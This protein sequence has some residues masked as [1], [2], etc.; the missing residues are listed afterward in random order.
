MKHLLLIFSCLFANIGFAQN[1]PTVR[2]EGDKCALID[3]QCKPIT[4][5]KYAYIDKFHENLALA[6]LH[7]PTGKR[8]QTYLNPKGQEI[9]SPTENQLF[10]FVAGRAIFKEKDKLGFLDK[11]GRAVVPATYKK[12]HNYSEGVA[13]VI[14][15][16]DKKMFIDEAGEVAFQVPEKYQF[17][18]EKCQNG[19][20]RVCEMDKE[21]P[22]NK[23][24]RDERIRKGHYV[25]FDKT[26]EI[27]LDIHQKMPMNSY[28]SAFEN[29]MALASLED[30]M[31]SRRNADT[32]YG[33]I[34][35]Q[36]NTLIPIKYDK[37]E[38]QGNLFLL[39]TLDEISSREYFGLHSASGKEVLPCIYKNIF[40]AMHGHYVVEVYK[41]NKDNVEN[42]SYDQKR[43]SVLGIVDTLGNTVI[44]PKFKDLWLVSNTEFLGYMPEK[45][46]EINIQNMPLKELQKYV[47]EMINQ[48]VE[49]KGFFAEIK[50]ESERK[51]TITLKE[52]IKSF[53]GKF[54]KKIEKIANKK[55]YQAYTFA[56]KPTGEATDLFVYNFYDEG[57]KQQRRKGL[58]PVQWGE[59]WALANSENK[60]ILTE[61][62]DNIAPFTIAQSKNEVPMLKNKKWL[63]MNQNFD[64]AHAFGNAEFTAVKKGGKWA[65]LYIS[66]KETTPYQYDSIAPNLK[67]IVLAVPHRPYEIVFEDNRMDISMTEML[68]I[69]YLPAHHFLAYQNKKWG[70]VDGFGKII[71]PFE[72]DSIVDVFYNYLVV[73]RGNKQGVINYAGKTLVDFQQ[74]N[75]EIVNDI[76]YIRDGDKINLYNLENKQI[77]KQ[78]YDNITPRND[79]T[80]IVKKDKKIGWIDFD[81]NELFPPIYDEIRENAMH[82]SRMKRKKNEQDNPTFYLLKKDQKQGLANLEY[83]IIIPCVYDETDAYSLQ[84]DKLIIVKQNN[85]K[86]IVNFKNEQILPFE[87]DQ[88]EGV[89]WH[90][91]YFKGKVLIQKDGKFGLIDPQGKQIL[92][93]HYD[94]IHALPRDKKI[95]A[96]FGKK[97]EVF[98]ENMKIVFSETWEDRHQWNDIR[99]KDVVGVKKN[100]KWGFVKLTGE[101]VIPFEYN[102]IMPFQNFING[103]S[104]AK[105]RKGKKWG[106]I[107][108]GGKVIIPCQYDAIENLKHFQITTITV[109]KNGKTQKIYF[110]DGKEREAIKK[111]EFQRN[112]PQEPE[113]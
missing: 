19:L 85:K 45:N 18:D 65:F 35:K 94:V 29:G 83:E 86:G 111:E 107:N 31:Q 2:Y 8:L 81:G 53:W 74:G 110:K 106:V 72:N 30:T 24:Q 52:E 67:K 98:D 5:Y 36:G 44:Q 23:Y 82:N 91:G 14:D 7:T 92:P 27:V 97:Q 87:Y 88:I 39:S 108:D 37:I 73:K 112:A 1:L 70:V 47:E 99:G 80:F 54:K 9:F 40:S 28:V 48:S 10:P 105:V 3:A 59:K 68:Q 55:I 26:G 96:F 58:L 21:Q 32:N 34:D 11:F 102:E 20:I 77:N 57:D 103:N 15:D 4:P 50:T 41:Y 62:L 78:N 64:A 63:F 76:A 38:K 60:S 51:D 79:Y 43:E 100:E 84:A 61:W 49:M 6:T 46:K 12:T 101:T 69:L 16:K 71:T 93:T 109:T 17:V 22:F 25:F 95:L 104:Y 33:V 75:I 113:E 89:S 13:L 56:G 42:L 90:K 66:G